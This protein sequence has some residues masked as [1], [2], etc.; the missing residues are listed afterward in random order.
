MIDILT[1]MYIANAAYNVKNINEERQINYVGLVYEKYGVDST[2]FSN[3]NLYYMSK[4][5]EYEKMHKEVL[6]RITNMRKEK[7]IEVKKADSIKN[8]GKN[9]DILK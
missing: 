8:A 3:S 5:D 7:E 9:F 4:I 2:V 1:D 6:E